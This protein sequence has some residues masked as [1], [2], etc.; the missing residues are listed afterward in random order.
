M[1]SDGKPIKQSRSLIIHPAVNVCRCGDVIARTF[2][3]DTSGDK[4]FLQSLYRRYPSDRRLDPT[5]GLVDTRKSEVPR[6]CQELRSLALVVQPVAQITSWTWD[7]NKNAACR[8]G[9]AIICRRYLQ[10]QNKEPHVDTEHALPSVCAW[11]ITSALNCW[12]GRD[13]SVGI[14]TRY[15]LYGSDFETSWRRNFSHSSRPAPSSTY[16]NGY[17]DR[18][19]RLK[20]PG[21]G[22]D[23]PI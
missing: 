14:A 18:F 3:L 1:S 10:R 6:T 16:I 22:V 8:T 21:H 5:D 2:T 20:L 13:G 9:G 11:P 7:R 19:W 23:L 17:R 4:C 12:S 15:E